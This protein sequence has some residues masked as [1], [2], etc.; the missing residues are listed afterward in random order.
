MSFWG[1]WGDM[2]SLQLKQ[3]SLNELKLLGAHAREAR[4]H[5]LAVAAYS[6]ILN[7]DH[8]HLGWLRGP[9]RLREYASAHHGLGISLAQLHRHKSAIE[10]YQAAKNWARLATD[11]ARE[12]NIN[13]DLAQSMRRTGRPHEALDLLIETRDQQRQAAQLLDAAATEG[14]I[15]R[16]HLQ[17]REYGDAATSA[18][19]AQKIL[20]ALAPDSRWY[21]YHLLPLARAQYHVGLYDNAHDTVR[22]L[23]AL[24]TKLKD[25]KLARSARTIL[26]LGVP[27][28]EL[29]CRIF[30]S[31]L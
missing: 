10:A 17:L 2:R 13:R 15:S 30:R 3:L 16:T 6:E 24:A 11:S 22:E 18:Y 14:F 23:L 31:E 8:E 4:D 7:N 20:K 29:L 21:L 25:R 28:F 19:K 27:G 5:R 26:V 12:L 9:E 1:V